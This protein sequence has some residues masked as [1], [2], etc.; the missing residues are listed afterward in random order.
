MSPLL[1]ELMRF[2][3][4]KDEPRPF[5]VTVPLIKTVG[6]DHGTTVTRPSTLEIESEL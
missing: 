6:W 2:T 1:L 4:D 5:A 3:V